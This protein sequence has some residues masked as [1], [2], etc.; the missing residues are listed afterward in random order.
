LFQATL[1]SEIGEEDAMRVGMVIGI[2]IALASAGGCDDGGKRP[3][4]GETIPRHASPSPTPAPT[5]SPPFVS[6]RITTSGWYESSGFG[7]KLN[8]TTTPPQM[9]NIAVP[10]TTTIPIYWVAA[11]KDWSAADIQA[12]LDAA[13]KWFAI[14]CVH[15][16]FHEVVIDDKAKTALVSDLAKGDA[17][18]KYT[19][20]VSAEFGAL[21]TGKKYIKDI[22]QKL[23]VVMFVDEYKQVDFGRGPVHE[24]GNFPY[25]PLILIT[26]S[27]KSGEE[28]LA[29]ELIHGLGKALGGQ[30]SN[31]W[32][33][34]VNYTWSEGACLVEMGN[35]DRKPGQPFTKA[36]D[37]PL[38]WASFWEWA[39]G[40]HTL[41]K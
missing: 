12:K 18:G 17:S 26:A 38:D 21:F 34:G 39:N 14:Y 1:P 5:C 31:P 4:K 20:V 2:V 13:T 37:S 29:H 3:P 41:K 10:G 23:L 7:P 40:A 11:G 19:D 28:I 6:G 32:V 30:K 35:P 22:G 24:S 25:I 27:D 16:D 36:S 8:C 9:R 33:T 15:L